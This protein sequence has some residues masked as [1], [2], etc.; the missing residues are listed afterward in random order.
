MVHSITAKDAGILAIGNGKG[1]VGKSTFTVYTAFHYAEKGYKV[2]VIDLDN[3]GNS[4]DHL[5]K[6]NKS[7]NLPDY[8]KKPEVSTVLKGKAV[9]LFNKPL[10]ESQLSNINGTISIF[11]PDI[12]LANLGSNMTI[13]NINTLKDNLKNL[14]KNKTIIIFDTPPTLGDLLLVPLSVSHVVLIPTLLKTYAIDGIASYLEFAN[15]IKKDWNPSLIIGG[16][17]PNLVDKKSQVQTELLKGIEM[18]GKQMGLIYYENGEILHIPNKNVIEE[19]AVLGVA[20]W[21][22]LKTSTRPVRKTFNTLFEQISKQLKLA[23]KNNGE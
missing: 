18:E 7:I 15:K 8:V 19:A 13:E 22:I 9:D 16:L 10:N 12:D 3:Q 11:S 6:F 2:I 21:H 20:T 1:G 23:N 17:I 4:S 5:L 14:L